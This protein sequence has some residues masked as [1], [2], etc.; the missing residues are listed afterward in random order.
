MSE[1]KLYGNEIET[2]TLTVDTGEFGH[3]VCITFSSGPGRSEFAFKASLTVEDAQ[4]FSRAIGTAIDEAV[5]RIN[6]MAAEADAVIDPPPPEPEDA[7]AG[8]PR[9][10][11]L[12]APGQEPVCL[13]MADIPF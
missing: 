3:E 10:A 7:G 11:L 1:I 12:L 2:G 6:E 9:Y 8:G 4:A 13:D 5:D